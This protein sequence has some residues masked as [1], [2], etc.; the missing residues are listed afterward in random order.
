MDDEL[1]DDLISQFLPGSSAVEKGD[2]KSSA[3]RVIPGSKRVFSAVSQSEVMARI[4]K[5]RSTVPVLASLQQFSGSC[6]TS[7]PA[8][9]N[10]LI[11]REKLRMGLHDPKGLL[12]LVGPTTNA[13]ERTKRLELLKTSGLLNKS[14]GSKWSFSEKLNEATGRLDLGLGGLSV[15]E[16]L[17]FGEK[18]LSSP[19][20]LTA[21][22]ISDIENNIVD[23]KTTWRHQDAYCKMIMAGCLNQA[24]RI[25]QKYDDVLYGESPELLV[26]S[27]YQTIKNLLKSKECREF[28]RE[29]DGVSEVQRTFSSRASWGLLRQS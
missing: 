29:V 18:V 22:N 11:T 26:Q 25:L 19:G 12:D 17:T 2:L 8:K 10:V 1:D 7:T 15:N 24:K 27:T 20:F 4:P 3:S 28:L 23:G 6:E 14:Q 9:K 21:K 13:L 16:S 5:K